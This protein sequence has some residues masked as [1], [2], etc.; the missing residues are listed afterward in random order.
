MIRR[1]ARPRA[2]A[3]DPAAPGRCCDMPSCGAQGEYRAPK[4]R[5]NLKDYWWFCL[6]HVRAYNGSWDY[7][8]GMSPAQMEAQ[9]RADTSWDRPSWPLGHIGG[10]AWDD[11]MLRDPLFIA[12]AAKTQMDISPASGE[13]AQKIAASMIGMPA[14]IVARAKALMEGS[15]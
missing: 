14:P 8:K 9:L 7:Y 12:D 6:D 15:R 5:D 10:S 13:E 2:Y 3:P 4:S 11:D 1:N